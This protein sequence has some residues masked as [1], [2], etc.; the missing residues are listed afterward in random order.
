VC[1]GRVPA[2]IRLL[3]FLLD[4]K[5]LSPCSFPDLCVSGWMGGMDGLAD[6]AM[7][8]LCTPILVVS[9]VAN[10]LHFNDANYIL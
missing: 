3:V 7:K 2:T 9:I 5:V 6:P 1:L 8:L 10:L 4:F